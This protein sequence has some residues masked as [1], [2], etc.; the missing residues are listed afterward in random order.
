MTLA[1]GTAIDIVRVERG[2]GYT[3]R[4]SFSNGGTREIDFESFLRRSH[5]PQIRVYLDPQK[6]ANFRLEYGNLMWDD[7][8]LCFPLADLYEGNI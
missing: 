2:P 8:A 4:L 6:F 3:L 1:E 5:N 7:Y